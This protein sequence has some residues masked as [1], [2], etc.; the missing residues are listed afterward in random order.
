MSFNSLKIFGPDGI[1]SSIINSSTP[2]PT[3]PIHCNTG[4][5][6][7]CVD[8]INNHIIIYYIDGNIQD[9]GIIAN[10]GTNCF[11]SCDPPSNSCYPDSVIC[12][13]KGPGSYL[14]GVQYTSDR[15]MIFQ[16]NDGTSCS[17]GE[18][19]KC[20]TVIFS[21]NQIP[22][23]DCPP[24][25]CGDVFVNLETGDIYGFFGYAWDIIGNIKGATGPT[26]LLGPTGPVGSMDT[27]T[28]TGVF[29]P[30]FAND[31][32]YNQAID[33]FR[34]PGTYYPTFFG[35]GIAT[36]VSR[37]PHIEAVVIGNHSDTVG[38]NNA[39]NTIAIGYYSGQQNQS[40]GAI[41]IGYQAGY[42][43]QGNDAIAIGN[44]AGQNSQAAN[45]IVINATGSTLDNTTASSTKL[46][47]IRNVN[48]ASTQYLFYN[49]ST[50]EVTWGSV[51]SAR[52]YKTD[53]ES[54]TMDYAQKM[55]S[56]EPVTFTIKDTKVP[57]I[58]FIAED[59]EPHLPEVVLHNPVTDEPEGIDYG[60]MVAPLLLLIKE[61]RKRINILET[62]L[63]EYRNTFET[64]IQ[65]YQV[66]IS[67][68][69]NK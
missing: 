61:Q 28:G 4:V 38:P 66:R 59:V 55:L 7:V 2:T 12:K 34:Q 27:Y 67:N 68:L 16:Y 47:P 21:Q 49:N 14:N 9:T 51:S 3:P 20:Q 41:A 48:Q 17:L 62:S 52:R 31:I 32:S 40:T 65:D 25:K 50:S 54:M 5:S 1:C 36:D 58:G 37:T 10:C 60:N 64:I 22:V 11:T 30:G 46:A 56:L 24:A 39:A 26:G 33:L 44:G 43:S 45:S 29:G 53:I 35:T 19:C 18:V 57:S 23:C 15:E 13:P 8:P 69:E 6:Q 42:N 63:Q